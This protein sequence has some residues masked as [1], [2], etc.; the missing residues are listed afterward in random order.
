MG[1]IHTE[2]SVCNNDFKSQTCKY[3]DYVRY[4]LMPTNFKTLQ[5]IIDLSKDMP[6]TVDR[7]DIQ[8]PR[9]AGSG[10][11]KK[12]LTLYW[13][14]GCSHCHN[15]MPE[16]KKLGKTHKGVKIQA[17]ERGKS[18]RKDIAGFPTILFSDGQR[19]IQY[20][21]PRTKSGF[22]NFLKNNL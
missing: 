19:E 4:G 12:S 7:V 5:D 9:P 14:N 21:G 18:K 10:K 22:V 13:A 1:N 3:Y 16:W 15:M 6:E 2:T 11:G 8:P 20:E 17:I